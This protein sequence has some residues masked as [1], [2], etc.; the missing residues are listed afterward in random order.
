MQPTL[1]VGDY[2]MVDKSVYRGRAPQRGD[3]V[4]FAY[5]Q[6]E[7]RDF[8][9]RIIGMPGDVVQVRGQQVFVNGKA[10]VEPYLRHTNPALGHTGG[11]S[12]SCRYLYACNP[13]MVPPDSYFVMSD[14]RDNSQ[15]SRYW[16]YVKREKIKGKASVIYRSWDNDRHWLRS[17]RVGRSL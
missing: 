5:P 12:P 3:I 6:D 11:Q 10:L 4:V 7:R 16:G 15:D 13:A 2:I 9:K 8:I 1:L 14:N 17:D